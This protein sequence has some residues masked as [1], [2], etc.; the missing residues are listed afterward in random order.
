MVNV[1]EQNGTTSCFSVASIPYPI[2][3]INTEVNL[4]S[5]K[6]QVKK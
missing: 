1:E 3:E 2:G 5:R 6:E 4:L